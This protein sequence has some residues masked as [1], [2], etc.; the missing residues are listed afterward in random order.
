MSVKSQELYSVDLSTNGSHEPAGAS[1]HWP[2]GPMFV[3]VSMV[4]TGSISVE[5]TTAD[6]GAWVRVGSP[7]TQSGMQEINLPDGIQYRVVI[8]DAAGLSGH[9][10]VFVA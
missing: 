8:S 7:M 1:A 2:G 6:L 10:D 4:G 3:L 9:V 5:V